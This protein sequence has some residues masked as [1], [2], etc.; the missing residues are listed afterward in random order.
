LLRAYGIQCDTPK[1]SPRCF[2]GGRD[3]SIGR[4]A[5]LNYGCFLDGYAEIRIGE[6]CFFGPQ[7]ML[8]TSTHEIGDA[9]ERGGRKYGEPI[10]IGNGCWLGARVTVMPGVTIG[11]GCVVASGSVVTKDCEPNGLY[12][13][14]PATRKKTLEPGGA[15]RAAG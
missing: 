13:G 1:V 11:E 15:A 4:G 2:F 8:I 14:V 6:R 3:I 5:F 7:V 10:R 9:S 12:A